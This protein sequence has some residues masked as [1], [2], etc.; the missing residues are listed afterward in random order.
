M[1]PGDLGISE[2]YELLFQ[3]LPYARANYN[4]YN[5][6]DSIIWAMRVVLDSHNKVSVLSFR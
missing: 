6:Q 3:W 4:N 1:V 2:V 5:V